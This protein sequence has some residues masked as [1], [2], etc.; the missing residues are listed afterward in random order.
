MAKEPA[1]HRQPWTSADDR[2][3]LGLAAGNTR[4]RL[5]AWQLDRSAD[6]TYGRASEIGVL[7]VAGG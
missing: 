1:H 7:G 4:T 6:A 2:R 3:P 5:I